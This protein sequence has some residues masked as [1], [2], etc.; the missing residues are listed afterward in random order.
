M[1][2]L[3]ATARVGFFVRDAFF[4]IEK[5]K[6]FY[7]FSIVVVVVGGGGVFRASP[8]GFRPS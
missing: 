8:L 4:G 1:G 6:A 2:F 7:S 5:V 3:C